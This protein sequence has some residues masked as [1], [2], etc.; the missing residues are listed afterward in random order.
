M[1]WY[2][3]VGVPGGEFA[4]WADN[5]Q[6]ALY[7]LLEGVDD[8]DYSTNK[9]FGPDE[10][11][12]YNADPFICRPAPPDL[13][14]WL[15]TAMHTTGTDFSWHRLKV[16]GG[17]IYQGGLTEVFVPVAGTPGITVVG[18]VPHV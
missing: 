11:E 12:H 9:D 5:Q 10:R 16:P 2:V 7:A 4:V 14:E 6:D 8:L 1:R 18:E 3:T 17:W 13:A 15:D